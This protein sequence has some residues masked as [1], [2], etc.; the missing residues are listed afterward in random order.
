M[1][2]TFESFEQCRADLGNSFSM[3]YRKAGSGHPVVLLHGWP[4][5]SLMW[6][7]I[8]PRLAEKF[9]VILPDL[10]G[11]GASTITRGGYDKN[12]MA[13]DVR[14]LVAQLNLGPIYLAGYD[15]GAGV[16]CAYARQFRDEVR[17]LA[18]MEF[19]LAGFGFEQQ[20][21]PQ[22]A[23]HLGSNWHLALFSVPRPQ[24]GYAA[25]VKE[26]FCRGSSGIF[27][28][29]AAMSAV[30]ILKNMCGRSRNQA[31]CALDSNTMPQFGRTRK[32]TKNSR[33]RPSRCLRWL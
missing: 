15:L 12:A 22:P 26:N 1:P 9:T 30:N 5:H 25:A 21:T 16:A 8:A 33:V 27:P 7:S 4:Q 17:R 24:S 18:V 14:A 13:Q 23:W 6:H 32:T 19:G 3:A 10:R 11:A 2:F 20:M 29:Q 31:L 28:M